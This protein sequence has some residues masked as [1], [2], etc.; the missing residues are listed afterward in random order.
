MACARTAVTEDYHSNALAAGYTY[1]VNPTTVF[2]FNASVSRFSYNRS[3]ENS[4]FDLT[5]IGWPAS[6]NSVVPSEMRTPPTPCVANFADSIMCTQ[7]QS[8]IQD[9]NTQYYCHAVD[10]DVAGAASIPFGVPVRSRTGQLRSVQHRQR[11]F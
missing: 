8:F 10:V 1:S 2:G 6:Y 3:P 7:G 9:R 5:T 4:G 11:V